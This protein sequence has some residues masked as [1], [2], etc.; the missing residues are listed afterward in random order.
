MDTS[1]IARLGPAAQRQIKAKLLAQ[2]EEEQNRPK[3]GPKKRS[4]YGNEKAEIDGI[5]FDSRKEADRYR[6]LMLLLKAGKI[7]DLRLQHEFLLQPAFTTPHGKRVRSIRYVADF[8]YEEMHIIGQGGCMDPIGQKIVWRFVVEDVK[9]E[10]TRKNKVYIMK[11]K[12]MQDKYGIT[13][14]EA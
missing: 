7:R 14:R 9:S 1:D 4:K 11:K 6:E 8:T 2:L 10:A 13:I 3:Q 5:K 12:M